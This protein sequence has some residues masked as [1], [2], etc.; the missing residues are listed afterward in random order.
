MGKSQF[1]NGI[2]ATK[3]FFVNN[4][5]PVQAP[6]KP[7]PSLHY[8]D[9]STVILPAM[10][11]P[12][13]YVVMDASKRDNALN[14]DASAVKPVRKPAPKGPW[15]DVL[16]VAL[17]ADSFAEVQA[18]AEAEAEAEKVAATV[19]SRADEASGSETSKDTTATSKSMALGVLR[20][21]TPSTTLS[22]SNKASI[23][24]KTTNQTKVSTTLAFSA[25]LHAADAW[26]N[27][28]YKAVVTVK[29]EPSTAPAPIKAAPAPAAPRKPVVHFPDRVKL[30]SAPQSQNQ[31]GQKSFAAAVIKKAPA[32]EPVM[33]FV[34][35]PKAPRQ[36]SVK[37]AKGDPIKNAPS[38]IKVQGSAGEDVVLPTKK[39]SDKV[40]KALRIVPEASLQIPTPPA[41]PTEDP[42]KRPVLAF[43]PLTPNDTEA[44]E[45]KALIEPA[46]TEKKVLVQPTPTEKTA[47]PVPEPKVHAE[48]VVA[49]KRSKSSKKAAK[50]TSMAPKAAPALPAIEPA[51]PAHEPT[52][53]TTVDDKEV[54]SI[55]PSKQIVDKAVETGTNKD[56]SDSTSA[57]DQDQTTDAPTKKKRTQKSGA[58]RKRDARN[59]AEVEVAQAIIDVA[60]A[61]ALLDEV[62]TITSTIAAAAV[63][64]ARKQ[65]MSNNMGALA[66]LADDAERLTMCKV[67]AERNLRQSIENVLARGFRVEKKPS[68]VLA[69]FEA[70]KAAPSEQDSKAE[71]AFTMMSK[72][73][74]NSVFNCF[75]QKMAEKKLATLES[76]EENY[77]TEEM[78]PV[79]EPRKSQRPINA[80]DF[81]LTPDFDFGTSMTA[82]FLSAGEVSAPSFVFGSAGTQEIPDIAVTQ[83]G[84]APTL[85]EEF[86]ISASSKEDVSLPPAAEEVV[87]E[88]LTEDVSFEAPTEGFVPAPLHEKIIPEPLA[89]ETTAEQSEKI[90]AEI[91]VDEP[92]LAQDDSSLTENQLVVYQAPKTPLF[93]LALP[94]DEVAYSKLIGPERPPLTAQSNIP[95][96]ALQY[97]LQFGQDYSCGISIPRGLVPPASAIEVFRA[98]PVPTRETE[99]VIW[100]LRRPKRQVT[101]HQMLRMQVGIIPF[102]DLLRALGPPNTIRFSRL[103]LINA[104]IALS[105]WERAKIDEGPAHV[106]NAETVTRSKHLAFKISLGSVSLADFLRLIAFDADGGTSLREVTIAWQHC[107]LKDDQADAWAEAEWALEALLADD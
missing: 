101:V 45:K 102:K 82:S 73:L 77:D 55:G 23:R 67:S 47:S 3:H 38:L 19:T 2:N 13:A 51:A 100:H 15:L 33:F 18:E 76:E 40:I 29:N 34:K 95:F 71:I 69:G 6:S 94:K 50:K 43:T 68:S 78:A 39:Q 36:A 35:P 24:P 107:S 44:V 58:Q 63:V 20:L 98:N 97:I 30:C 54:A 104:F 92:K 12:Y 81:S 41:S 103:A 79:M 16:G 83:D 70:T 85:P 91:V 84:S 21:L 89:K 80:E 61:A 10:T 62:K 53:T 56:Q 1:K 17:P 9:R 106:Y 32:I 86:T 8:V 5:A 105:S 60:G 27:V 7:I 14:N 49:R 87:S 57:S 25:P 96:A 99:L 28:S 22:H 42:A 64:A 93:V 75:V 88:A 52:I 72:A 74:Y 11:L 37:Q 66:E 31:N 46:L 48:P 26:M 4:D 59:R 65:I 90:T